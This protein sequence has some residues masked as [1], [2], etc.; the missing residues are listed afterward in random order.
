[1]WPRF[2]LKKPVIEKIGL[3]PLMPPTPTGTAARLLI[4]SFRV[5]ILTGVPMSERIK[6]A[7]IVGACILASPISPFVAAGYFFKNKDTLCHAW[8]PLTPI[9][10][11]PL[12][13]L[14]WPY[15]LAVDSGFI[16]RWGPTPEEIEA[17]RQQRIAKELRDREQ[18]KAP[19][20]ARAKE[21]ELQIKKRLGYE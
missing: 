13:G 16:E 14:T 17:E 7:F 21:R 19:V 9:I 20:I 10:E 18:R 5:R 1:M 6:N 11:P 4:W 2:A 3:V 15:Q 12:F 8:H